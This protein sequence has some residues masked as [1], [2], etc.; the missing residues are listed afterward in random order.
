[1]IDIDSQWDYNDPAGSEMRLR[2]L[3]PQ[4][5][6]S[7]DAALE[8]ELLTQIARAMGLQMRFDEAH[9]LLD[10]A[11]AL[12]TPDMPQAAVRVA[13]ERGRLIN[14][15]GDPGAAFPHFRMGMGL[16][17][18]HAA[19]HPRHRRGAHAGDCDRRARGARLERAGARHRRQQRRRTGARMGRIAVQHPRLGV[20]RSGRLQ[21][22]LAG[23]P[24]GVAVPRGA[25]RTADNPGRCVVRGP[26]SALAGACTTRR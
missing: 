12:L 11:Q 4:A 13:L 3:I 25:G 10:D 15:A 24:R 5:E 9:A 16:C 14:T 6:Q 7:G 21:P 26:L 1:M 2:A 17:P 8:A 19:G 18:R 22:R 23:V 20:S